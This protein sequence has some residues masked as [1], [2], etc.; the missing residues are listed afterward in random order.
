M[1]S[2]GIQDITPD[3]DRNSEQRLE[4]LGEFDD[5]RCQA[6]PAEVRQ[7]V[8]GTLARTFPDTR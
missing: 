5:T 3:T 4:R 8:E 6:A 7:Q 1:P 2:D